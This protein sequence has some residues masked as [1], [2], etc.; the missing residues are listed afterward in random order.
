MKKI[1]IGEVIRYFR[2]PEAAA[3]QLTGPLEIGDIIVIQGVTTNLE[4]RVDSMQI[5]GVPIEKAHA[6]QA[7]GIKVKER[8]REK[9][10][11]YKKIEE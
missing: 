8:V 1:E 4:Q 7:V 11:V 10:L 2:K 6:G 9:D 3:I 5:E